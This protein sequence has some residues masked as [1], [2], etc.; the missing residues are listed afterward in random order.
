MARRIRFVQD[1]TDRKDTKPYHISAEHNRADILTKI[2]SSR[3][4]KQFR[5]SI[6]NIAN[7]AAHVA[8]HVFKDSTVRYV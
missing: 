5:H 6:L 8:A 1:A 2:L 7:V 4:F 3:L